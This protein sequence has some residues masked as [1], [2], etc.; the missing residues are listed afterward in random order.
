MT[1]PEATERI[2]SMGLTDIVIIGVTG[3]VMA[4]DR[5]LFLSAGADAV[6]SKPLD[7]K[8]FEDITNRFR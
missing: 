3:N 4:D 5:A 1:G 2:R 6:L 7:I 8:E